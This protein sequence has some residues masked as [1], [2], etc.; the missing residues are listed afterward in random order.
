MSRQFNYGF[1]LEL[2]NNEYYLLT[3]L[4]MPQLQIKKPTRDEIF[5]HAQPILDAYLYDLLKQGK[6]IPV[7]QKKAPKDKQITP[8]EMILQALVYYV[9]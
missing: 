4:D 7:V 5:I 1:S 9:E 6:K 8:S 2:I 3:F